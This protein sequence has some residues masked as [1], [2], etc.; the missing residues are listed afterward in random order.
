MTKHWGMTADAVDSAPA[1]I[2]LLRKGRRYDL[3]LSDYQ[4]HPVDG[5]AFALDLRN[6]EQAH[7]LPHM[8][9]VILSSA[10]RRDAGA[11]AGISAI[12]S[13]PVKQSQLFDTLLALLAGKDRKVRGEDHRRGEFI[14]L[15]HQHPLH[16]LLAEDNPINQKLALR[17]L[18]RLGYRADVANDGNEVLQALGRQRYDV[19]LMDVHMPE[20]DGLE[21]SRRIRRTMPQELQPYIIAMTAN[22]ME[23]ARDECLSAGMNDYVSKPIRVNDLISAL[24]KAP[25]DK[26]REARGGERA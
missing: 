5:I 12:L 1:A 16:L 25:A 3:C 8:P 9:F 6:W 20:M 11:E 4:M 7:D 26:N 10:M 2:E 17:I 18:A 15:N 14:D 22:A 13:K 21:A 24:R 23:G 19:V